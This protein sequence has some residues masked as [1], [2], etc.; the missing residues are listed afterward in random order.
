MKK[1]LSLLFATLF[2]LSL[3]LGLCACGGGE[4]AD[5]PNVGTYICTTA[6]MEGISLPVE[7]FA[8]NGI[9]LE[10]KDSG[11]ATLDFDGESGSG[12]WTLDGTAFSLEADGIECP[13]TLEDGVLILDLEGVMLTFEKEAA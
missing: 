4:A 12:S 5:D 7:S 9:T 11:T 10:L 13:G 3:V 1:Q 2:T 8:T 6:E